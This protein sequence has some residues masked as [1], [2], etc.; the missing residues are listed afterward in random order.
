MLK[1]ISDLVE[2]RREEAVSFLQ[3]LIRIPSTSGQEEEAAR[4]VSDKL[5]EAGFSV[6]VDGLNDVMAL[7]KGAGGGRSLLLNGH[8]DHVPAGNMVDP[9]SGKL[10]DGAV[11]GVEGDV[12]YGRA[13]SDMKGALA[14]MVMAGDVLS[15][16]GVEL[17]GDFK[18]AA[19]AQEETS[20][21]GTLATI[22][23]GR[24][25][26]D[27]VVVGEATNMEVALGHRGGAGMDVFLRG[28]SCH[29]SA[30]ERGINALYKAVDLIS[31]IRSELVPRLP[32]HPVFGKT[33]LTVTRIAVKPDVANVVP[34]ECSF[35]I[36][37]RNGPDFPAAAL[38]SA[39]EEIISSI[40]AEDSEMSATVIPTRAINGPRGFTGFYTDPRT[41]HVVAEAVDAISEAL[42]H[43]P[44]TKTWSFATDGRFYS[45]LGIPVL[46]FGPGEERLAHTNDDHVRV[47]DYLDSIK[48]YAW[49]ACKICVVRREAR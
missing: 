24:F 30:P 22:E 13:A 16:I 1:A 27:V 26:G 33:T 17:M 19:V 21:A 32:T 39:L 14:A 4:L 20:G 38:K 11:F 29:A 45:W 23:K 3:S 47:S 35:H 42:G 12:V 31:R 9:Y 10:I 49:I 15:E 34:E 18:V 7:I 48:A 44:G 40:R 8:I 6:E 36:D 41:N 37:C 43:K 2:R 28:R 46:G 5:G 25:L